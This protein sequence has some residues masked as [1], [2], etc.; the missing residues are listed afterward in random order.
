MARRIAHE[1]KNP[2]TPIRLSAEHLREVYQ[3]DPEKAGAVLDQ[4]VANILQQVE[5]LREI[6]SDFS[7][8]SQIPVARLERGDLR[9]LLE[10]L[11]GG[12]AL[13]PSRTP[14]VRLLAGP[15]PVPAAFDPRLLER[16]VRNLIENALRASPPESE[17]L[18][19]LRR[20]EGGARIEV[21]DL[22]PGVPADLLEKIFEPYFSTR[23]H[24]TGLGLPIARRIV[25]EHGGTLDAHNRPG[26]GLVACIE[27]PAPP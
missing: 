24:G 3:R 10:R 27:L 4:C 21:S 11:A 1:I 22:G 15:E 16:A 14:T 7:T 13:A 5:N 19:E 23:D 18:V 2:L 9:Q 8:Y 12:Y 25:T 17:V 20:A 26:G 6:A